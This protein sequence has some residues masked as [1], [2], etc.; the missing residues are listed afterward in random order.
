[1]AAAASSTWAP[2]AAAAAEVQWQH[3]L[4]LCGTWRGVW[5]RFGA[6]EGSSKVLKPTRHFQAFCVPCAAA[7]GRSVHHVNRYPPLVAPPGGRKMAN[8]LTEVDFGRF[9]PGSFQTP[10]GPQSQAVYGPGWAGI[11]PK[12][13]QGSERIAVE[14]VSRMA[15]TTCKL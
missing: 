15:A 2:R 7:D 10:F 6:E 9:D 12:D 13:L 1:M 11:G 8:G 14:L 5:Q 3:F 4:D